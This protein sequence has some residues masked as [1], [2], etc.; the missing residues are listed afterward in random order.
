MRGTVYM[1]TNKTN[2]KSYI[3]QTKSLENRLKVHMAGKSGYL[4]SAAI[5]KYGIEDFD[6]FILADNII[7]QEELDTLEEQ[8][9]Q[10]Y[11]TVTPNGYNIRSSR[12]VVHKTRL[13][14]DEEKLIVSLY[15]ENIP[16]SEISKIIGMSIG[17][18]AKALQRNGVERRKPI[19][20]RFRESKIDIDVVLQMLSEGKSKQEIAQHF[21]TN[22]KYIW[23][24]MKTHN[25][26]EYNTKSK[27]DRQSKD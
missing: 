18:I 9:I 26:K 2:S 16:I 25:I 14:K 22:Y 12:S 4:L 24:Y 10:E 19:S 13:T 27:R 23:K 11:N 15:N 6:I 20:K 1:F 8:Y 21:N 5:C 17:G 7:T 3:G